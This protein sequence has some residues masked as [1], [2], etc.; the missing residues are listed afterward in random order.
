MQVVKFCLGELS[1][2]CYLLVEDDQCLVVDAA[3]DPNNALVEYIARH[4][5]KPVA[6]L[7][8]HG[9]FDHV[10]GVKQLTDK[11]DVD[12]YCNFADIDMAL[13]AQNNLWQFVCDDCFPNKNFTAGKMEIG[14][15]TFY[16]LSTPGHTPGSVCLFFDRVMFS[17]DTLFCG[18]VGRTDLPGGSMRQLRAS[19]NLLKSIND[20]YVVYP[21]HGK[22]TTL[23]AEKLGNVYMN[24]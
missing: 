8:T 17:G 9:H 19:L 14:K 11:Y 12:V 23:S 10:G 18:C 15:F 16:V 22:E 4:A 13:H 1:T 20:D 6:I 3:Y 21:G 24:L 2:N 7:L 5:L